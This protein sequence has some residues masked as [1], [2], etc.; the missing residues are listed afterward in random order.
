M[1]NGKLVYS[2]STIR[3]G[4]KLITSNPQA[5]NK[6]PVPVWACLRFSWN[7]LWTPL[8]RLRAPTKYP[9][10]LVETLWHSKCTMDSK[11]TK[12]EKGKDWQMY[13]GRVQKQE[14]GT[15]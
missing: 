3:L 9:Y 14:R 8:K 7:T 11:D 2:T 13:K 15:N 1:L 5:T 6:V 10:I 12:R 4:V